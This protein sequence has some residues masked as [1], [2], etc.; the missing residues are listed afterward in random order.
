MTLKVS[1]I[2]STHD[3]PES[4]LRCVD[5]ALSQSYPPYELIIVHDGTEDLSDRVASV[6]RPTGKRFRYHQQDG[7]SLTRSRNRGMELATG[8]ILLLLDDDVILPEDYLARLV[9]LYDSDTD[10]CVDVIGGV[11]IDPQ[12]V[13][14]S[15]RLWNVLATVSA[16]CRWGPRYI[17]ARYVRLPEKLRGKLV[18]PK[19]LSGGA[20]SLR[21]SA[22]EQ[23][24]FDETLTGYAFGED[25]DFSFRGG[26]TH[27]LFLAPDLKVLHDLAPQ[28]RPEMLSRGGVYVRNFLYIVRKSTGGGIGTYA[29]FVYDLMGTLLRYLIWGAIGLNR[30]NLRFARGML[31]EMVRAGW[32]SIREILCAS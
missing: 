9:E 25:L 22:A 2:F 10:G 31:Q 15:R 11:M 27:A 14:L 26:Q 13:R 23:L 3:R 7:P 29:L 24:R 6:L 17:V 1:V 16:L 8:D 19:R 28:G 21:R 30:G 4:L 5:S 20:I 12:E 18:V 32:G